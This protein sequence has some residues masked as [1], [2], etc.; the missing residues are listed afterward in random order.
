MVNITLAIT[1]QK[2]AKINALVTKKEA[3]ETIGCVSII[4]SDKTGTLT[5]NKMMVEVAYVDGKYIDNNDYH[6]N[7]YFEENCIVNSTADIEKDE[8]DY[9]Y[10]GSATECALLLYHRNK[11]YN[12]FRKEVNL[13]SQVPFNSDKKRMSSLINMKNNGV[14]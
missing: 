5:Q 12:K 13:V 11:D 1:M 7:S 10:I 14:F 4:C 6:S 2:M 8:K 3:C 9:K